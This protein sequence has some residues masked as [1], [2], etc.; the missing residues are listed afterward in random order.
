[1]KT[2]AEVRAAFWQG[3]PPN[4]RAAFK[5]ENDATIRSEWAEFV[6]MLLR[7]GHITEALADKV[8]L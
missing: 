6:D 3:M 2:E 8:T 7:D 4:T 1:M 5:H